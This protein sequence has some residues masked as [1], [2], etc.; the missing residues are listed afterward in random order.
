MFLLILIALIEFAF[1]F[2]TLNSLNYTA[3]DV[4]LIAAEGGDRSGTDCTALQALE[5]ELGQASNPGG[6]VAVEIYWSD[7]N[8]AL[9]SGQVNRYNRTGSMSCAGL[10]GNTVTL[11]IRPQGAR[12]PA[13]IRCNVLSSELRG[14]AYEARHDPGPRH[15]CL[16]LEGLPSGPS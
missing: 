5:R 1:A 10:D 14:R 3:R 6:V 8:G 2:S 15:P 4:A 7:Q 11:P 13:N 12:T 9:L 16:Q